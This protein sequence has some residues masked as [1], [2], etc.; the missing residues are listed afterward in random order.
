MDWLAKPL[1]HITQGSIVDGVDWGFDESNPLSIVLSNACDL[2]NGKSSFLM[3]AA[4]QPAVGVL[5]NSKEYQNIIQGADENKKLKRKG[6]ESLLNFLTGYIHNKNIGRYYFFDSKPIFDAGLLLVDFQ[7]V[8]A[9]N[10]EEREKVSIIAQM[11]SPFVEQMMMHFVSY[12]ARIPSDRVSKEQEV[13]YI[14][15][16]TNGFQFKN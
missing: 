8:K 3:V 9:L 7:L 11:I 5:T 6:W 12:T 14:E 1:D 10:M 4:L 15:E 16:L 13:N 2:E